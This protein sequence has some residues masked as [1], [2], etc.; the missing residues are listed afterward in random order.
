MKQQLIN[1][2]TEVCVTQKLHPTETQSYV[3]KLIK[4]GKDK[5]LTTSGVVMETQRNLWKLYP[6]GYL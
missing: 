4:E 6:L 1:H 2:L 5:T 3:R